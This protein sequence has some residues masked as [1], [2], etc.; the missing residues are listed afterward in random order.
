MAQSA[1]QLKTDALQASFFP[2][3]FLVSAKKIISLYSLVFSA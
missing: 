2:Y 3:K 1:A